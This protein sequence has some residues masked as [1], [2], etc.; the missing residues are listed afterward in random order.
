MQ[1]IRPPAEADMPAA[2]LFR[3]LLETPRPWVASD[4]VPGGRVF[5]I[6]ALEHH[7][8]RSEVRRAPKATQGLA[9]WRREVAA[10]TDLTF[11]ETGR[12]QPRR[13][14]SIHQAVRKAWLICDPRYDGAHDINAWKSRLDQGAAALPGVVASLGNCMAVM[15]KHGVERP[16]W[17]FG[18]GLRELTDGQWMAYRAATR[19]A[20][21]RRR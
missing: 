9:L 8:L 11:E 17:W 10:A 12:L 3:L 18:I 14:A 21:A 4:D 6:R 1:L 16:D 5:A 19:A 15:G 7:R 2:D 13:L 20:A